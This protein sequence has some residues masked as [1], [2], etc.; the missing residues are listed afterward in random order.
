MRASGETSL[1]GFP[2]SRHPCTASGISTPSDAPP[3]TSCLLLENRTQ[4]RASCCPHGSALL[5]R[6][7][8]SK[9]AHREGKRLNLGSRAP[10]E[11]RHSGSQVPPTGRVVS[12]D[13]GLAMTLLKPAVPGMMWQN[14][15]QLWAEPD[16]GRRQMTS[17]AKVHPL[18]RLGTQGQNG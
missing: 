18:L 4:V 15:A 2:P 17:E 10:S 5:W 7:F 9:E 12:E 13:E 1:T 6:T 8:G 3:K 14:Q 16:S 11:N